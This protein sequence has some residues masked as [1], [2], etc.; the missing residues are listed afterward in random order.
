M[1]DDK[2]NLLVDNYYDKNRF[3]LDKLVEMVEQVRSSLPT[4]NS[5]LPRTAKNPAPLQELAGARQRDR[6][7]RLP[8]VIPTEISVGQMPNST[9]R[10]QFEIWMSNIGMEGPGEK[11]DVNKK[12]TTITGFFDNLDARLENA[13]TP[14]LLSYLMFLNQ[15]VWMIKEF[16]AAVAGFLWEPFLAA[17]FGGKSEQVPASKGDIA[18]I[19]IWTRG[20]KNAPI[21]LKIL[22]EAG[23]VKGSFTDLVK[24]FRDTKDSNPEMRYV[25]VTKQQ[26][27][28]EKAVSSVTFWEFNIT[29]EEFF[30]W[31]GHV[32]YVEKLVPVTK[33]FSLAT[34]GKKAWLKMGSRDK[35]GG[36]GTYVWIRHASAG[37]QLKKRKGRDTSTMMG[38]TAKWLRLAKIEE[39]GISIDSNIAAAVD[40]QGLP[41][42]GSVQI[43]DSLSA[44]IADY[45]RGGGTGPAS[46]KTGQRPAARGKSVAGAT[47]KT[48]YVKFEGE[49]GLFADSKTTKLI[50]GKT[51]IDP[52]TKQPMPGFGIE[53]WSGLAQELNDPKQ[54]FAA[55]SGRVEGIPPAPGYA[56]SKGQDAAQFDIKPNHYKNLGAK[57]GVL[58]VTTKSV[59]DAFRKSAEKMNEDLVDMFNS[60]ADLTDNIGRFFLTDCGGD[61]CDEADAANRN[62]AGQNA[63]ENAHE[64]ERTVLS[65]VRRETQ[66]D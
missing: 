61:K 65:S 55:V 25:V 54:F 64:L 40:L 50:W 4:E 34:A 6:V 20:E 36:D 27:K 45:A 11:S 24:H 7:L 30:K 3:N 10:R 43:D 15:F 22:N 52:E 60:L 66:K 63:I 19:R 37:K 41:A 1:N 59:E 29:P 48:D 8:N 17:L 56:K 18:D 42:E 23:S 39:K 57:L 21:S 46:A 53:Y 33:T 26:T 2:I 12:L 31:I 44:T 9:D 28:K 58:K 49:E 47:V 62:A 14:E 16:N 5:L 38:A 13:S 32:H 35:V 51:K